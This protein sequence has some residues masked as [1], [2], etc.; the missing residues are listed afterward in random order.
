MKTLIRLAE[1]ATDG[2]TLMSDSINISNDGSEGVQ[3]W[4]GR[5][6][7]VYFCIFLPRPC[8]STVTKTEGDRNQAANPATCVSLLS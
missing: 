4:E 5:R 3:S 1:G 7:R 2:A 6:R 8:V